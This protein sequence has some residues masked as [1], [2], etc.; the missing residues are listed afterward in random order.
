MQCNTEN[1]H[2][3]NEWTDHIIWMYLKNLYYFFSKK[4]QRTVLF[5]LSMARAIK[6]HLPLAFSTSRPSCL[7]R[8]FSTKFSCSSFSRSCCASVL[9]L[10]ATLTVISR[11]F[12][13]CAHSSTCQESHV[14]LPPPSV[15]SSHWLS[16]KQVK[17]VRQPITLFTLTLQRRKYC[18]DSQV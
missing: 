16:D 1:N 18:L 5:I 10:F 2:S 8:S 6:R 14:T 9:K 4:V 13:N 11:S 17:W 3:Y 15:T 7:T 12:W